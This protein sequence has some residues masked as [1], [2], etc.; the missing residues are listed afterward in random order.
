[1]TSVSSEMD[2][3]QGKITGLQTQKDLNAVAIEHWE[4]EKQANPRNAATYNRYIDDIKYRNGAGEDYK[5]KYGNVP[6]NMLEK[7]EATQQKALDEYQ[8]R[9]DGLGLQLQE[10]LMPGSTK[11]EAAD[12]T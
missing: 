5:P 8:K 9:M 7:Q 12:E 4:A 2:K 1:M 6:N 11:E 3:I 10:L